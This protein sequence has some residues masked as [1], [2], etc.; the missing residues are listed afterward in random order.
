MKAKSYEKAEA[1][2][3]DLKNLCEEYN[4]YNMY[5]DGSAMGPVFRI[6]G[7][8]RSKTYTISIHPR[9]DWEDEYEPAEWYFQETIRKKE[10]KIL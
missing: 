7:Q 4:V 9:A 6:D 8:E 10:V 5:D 3:K 1:F 2:L